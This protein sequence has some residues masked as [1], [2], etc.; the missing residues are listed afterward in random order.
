MTAKPSTELRILAIL[1]VRDEGPFLI[2]WVA[3]ARAVGFTDI[4]A[5]SNDCRDGT[6]LILDRLA[7]LG[8]LTHVRND[9]PHR[10]GPQWD[11]L[12]RAAKHPLAAAADWIAVI[13]IDE[14]VNIRTGQG[15]LPDLLTILP[16]ATAIALT[17]RL[18]GNAGVVGFTDRPVTEAFTRAAPADLEWPWRASLFKTLYRNDGSYGAPGVHR[19]R[20]PDR[21]RMGAQ[22]W[23]DGSGRRLPPEFHTSRVFTRPGDVSSALVQLNHYPLGAMESYVLKCDRG[24]ANREASPLDVSYWV[25]RNF[26][27]VEERSI[28]RLRP[29]SDPIRDELR[30]DPILSGL[31]EAAIRWRRARFAELMREEDWRAL[32]ARLMITPPSRVLSTGEAALLRNLV[33]RSGPVRLAAETDGSTGAD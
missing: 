21:S 31:H 33:P 29:L 20:R 2:D 1:T 7:E 10:K 11:A 28:A 12:N 18:F 6:D 27:T 8:R 4:L 9:A 3:H 16:D 32:F 14:F 22:R 5:F 30:A 23:Y 25:E 17:W 24:R 26:G 15:T 13:D 19:P